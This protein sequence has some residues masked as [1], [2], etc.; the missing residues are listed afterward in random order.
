MAFKK[1][2][3]ADA[4]QKSINTLM[5]ACIPTEEKK[6]EQEAPKPAPKPQP[7]QPQPVMSQASSMQQQ[8]Q[9]GA[10]EAQSQPGKSLR[11]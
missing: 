11:G 7:T 9:S 8:S 6:I 1:Y 4:I 10:P 3:G 5:R 2:E